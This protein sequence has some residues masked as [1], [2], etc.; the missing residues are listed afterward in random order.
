MCRLKLWRKSFGNWGEENIFPTNL[1]SRQLVDHDVYTVFY[2]HHA[3]CDS[4][5]GV[6]IMRCLKSNHIKLIIQ[7]F[8]IVLL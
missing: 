8:L 6:V 1:D 7:H 3:L 2:G 5:A 4:I